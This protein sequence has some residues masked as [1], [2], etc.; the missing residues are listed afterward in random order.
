[1]NFDLAQA[2]IKAFRKAVTLAVQLVKDASI[3]I[4]GKDQQ[5]TK[6]L[7]QKC[8]STTLNSKLVSDLP[9]H[10]ADRP[11][12][13]PLGRLPPVDIHIDLTLK[14]LHW[15]D[16]SRNLAQWS[17]DQPA[18]VAF[19][20]LAWRMPSLLPLQALRVCMSRRR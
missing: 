8:A 18:L 10:A 13:Q 5:D 4:E 16:H 17:N 9:W 3:S 11:R 19:I 14:A 12:L 1:M 7:L 6:A 15:R 2:I 20:L